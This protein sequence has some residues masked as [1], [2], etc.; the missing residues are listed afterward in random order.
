MAPTPLA[1]ALETGCEN[2]F[3]HTLTVGFRDSD[4]GHGRL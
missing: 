2:L 4:A 1:Q 3:Q